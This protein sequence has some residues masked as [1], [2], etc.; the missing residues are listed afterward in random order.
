MASEQRFADLR[1]D[2]ERKGWG[3]ARIR[4]SHHIFEKPGSANLVVP[5]HQGKVKPAYVRQIKKAIEGN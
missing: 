5:V 3:L 2:L 4:G 1:R